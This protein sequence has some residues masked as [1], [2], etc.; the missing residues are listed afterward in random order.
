MGPGHSLGS[1]GDG[2][3]LHMTA[4]ETRDRAGKGGWGQARG[5]DPPATPPAP[6]AA[7]VANAAGEERPRGPEVNCGTEIGHGMEIGMGIGHGMEILISLA[8][9]T[10]SPW[11]SPWG[12]SW[13]SARLWPLAPCSL[14]LRLFRWEG[15][16]V[17]GRAR[18]AGQP[19]PGVGAAKVPTTECCT[20]YLASLVKCSLLPACACTS[21]GCRGTGAGEVGT[22]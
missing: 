1:S 15:S 20:F 18:P 13:L 14:W 8:G 22:P 16:G 6:L 7:G 3:I 19:C 10:C 2:Y 5:R 17:P 21:L 12:S 11:G 4:Q 9:G